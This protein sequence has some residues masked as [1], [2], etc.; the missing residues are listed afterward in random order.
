MQDDEIERFFQIIHSRR[1]GIE[2]CREESPVRA[3]GC[4]DQIGDVPAGGAHGAPRSENPIGTCIGILSPSTS[5]G[6]AGKGCA[7]FTTSTASSSNA[8]KP[9]PRP[10]DTA[11]TRPPRSSVRLTWARPSRF[12]ILAAGG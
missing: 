11:S 7:R 4:I 12:I 10:R 2:A 6:G 9:A 1:Q 5:G 3:D 8:L